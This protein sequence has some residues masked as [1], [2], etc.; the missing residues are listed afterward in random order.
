MRA[1]W[2]IE[3]LLEAMAFIDYMEEACD[4]DDLQR[5]RQAKSI[6]QDVIAELKG[7]QAAYQA[8]IEDDNTAL[9][10]EKDKR[11]GL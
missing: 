7:E 5:V 11:R 6:I 10:G 9:Y 1:A 3:Q 8:K 2:A 4:Y